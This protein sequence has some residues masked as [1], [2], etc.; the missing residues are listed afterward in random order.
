M[1]NITII[2]AGPAGASAVL[3]EPR[4]NKAIAAAPMVKRILRV[5]GQQGL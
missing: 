2:G 4:I 3:T 5:Y 1:Y